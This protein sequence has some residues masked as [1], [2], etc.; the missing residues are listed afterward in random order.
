MQH[1]FVLSV[2]LA[3]IL[4]G[5]IIRIHGASRALTISLHAAQY[6]TTFY[7]LAIGLSVVSLL[8][9]LFL[10]LWLIPERTLGDISVLF[11]LLLILWILITSWIPDSIG[12][13]RTIHRA[14]AYC[15][16]VTIP[17]LL[18]SLL[19]FQ[20]LS[21]LTKIIVSLVVIGQL[22]MLYLLFWVTEAR[23]HFLTYQ[24]AYLASF[25][26]AMSSFIYLA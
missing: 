12:I 2:I 11:Y 14:A 16:V 26:L 4:I 23:K 22:Y 3:A 10:F 13:K 20:T 1:V 9:I 5:T 8:N 18:L 7:L 15:I 17:L 24:A 21:P 6:P 25:F 19:V